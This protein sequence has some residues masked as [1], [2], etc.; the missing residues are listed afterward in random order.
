[1]KRS[2]IKLH[3]S[4]GHPHCHD[5][6]RMPRQSTNNP[7]PPVT[8][9]PFRF[10]TDPHSTSRA[11][12]SPFAPQPRFLVPQSSPRSGQSTPQRPLPKRPE[13]EQIVDSDGDSSIPRKRR[14]L[15]CRGDDIVTDND[16]TNSDTRKHG[17]TLADDIDSSPPSSTSF[18]A[19]PSSTTFTLPTLRSLPRAPCV[20]PAPLVE[21]TTPIQS[22][23]QPSKPASSYLKALKPL[24]TIPGIPET[25]LPKDWSPS[26]KR[27]SKWVPGGFAETVCAWVVES[28][29]RVTLTNQKHEERITIKLVV[30]ENGQAFVIGREDQKLLLISTRKERL[31]RLSVDSCILAGQPVSKFMLDDIEWSICTNWK[32]QE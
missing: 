2:T 20:Q 32:L 11:Q 1:M 18:T 19:T 6:S 9:S 16:D 17:L 4:F 3:R 8:P 14:L 23:G 15:A 28:E 22:L 7:R 5:A 12:A 10:V 30:I 29:S 25:V 13:L 31:H 24:S 27:G 26:R 21:P